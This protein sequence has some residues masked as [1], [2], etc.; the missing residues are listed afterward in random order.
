MLEDSVIQI[1]QLNPEKRKK[2]IR[3]TFWAEPRARDAQGPVSRGRRLFGVA[4]V[5]RVG[6]QLK[7]PAVAVSFECGYGAIFNTS[8][9]GM[10]RVHGEIFGAALPWNA[11]RIRTTQ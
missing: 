3:W 1:G 2:H 6:A 11:P 4:E 9:P 8:A 10:S 7:A 5:P